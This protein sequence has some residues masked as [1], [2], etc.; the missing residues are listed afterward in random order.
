MIAG[1]ARR[2][3]IGAAQH[4]RFDPAVLGAEIGRRAAAASR[5]GPA[6]RDALRHAAALAQAA[7]DHLDRDQFDRLLGAG[8]MAVGA[9][10]LDP[11]A[12]S[13]CAT[14]AGSIGPSGTGTV[15]S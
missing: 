13:R 1:P 6:R 11:N 2:R 14:I 7:A 15:S 5:L 4:R 12:S 10:V 8:A 3:E 9:L